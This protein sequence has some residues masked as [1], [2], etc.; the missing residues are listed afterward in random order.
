MRD[1]IGSGDAFLAAFLST[2]LDGASVDESLRFA[3]AIGALVA[4]KSGGTPVIDEDELD[5][6]YDANDDFEA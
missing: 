4:T 5:E 3:C 6:I 2:N 1:T